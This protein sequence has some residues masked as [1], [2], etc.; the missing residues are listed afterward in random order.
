MDG[1]MFDCT[2]GLYI[3]GSVESASVNSAIGTPNDIL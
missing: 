3:T 2:D 1:W